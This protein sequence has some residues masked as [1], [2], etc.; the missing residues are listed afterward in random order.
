[1][2]GPRSSRWK[3]GGAT[4]T[5]PRRNRSASTAWVAGSGPARPRMSSRTLVPLDIMWRTTRTAA[6]SSGGNW[7]TS[8]CSAWTPP[9]EAPTTITPLWTT[10]RASPGASIPTGGVRSLI[11]DLLDVFALQ[12]LGLGLAPGGLLVHRG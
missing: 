3:S 2:W 9:A 10:G 8:A 11:L 1:M 6:G 4:E 12:L 7:A 5:W